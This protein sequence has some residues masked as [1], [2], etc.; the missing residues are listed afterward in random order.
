MTSQCTEEPYVALRHSQMI[1][2]KS[3]EPRKTQMFKLEGKKKKKKI[4]T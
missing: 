3:N 2:A 1:I 4:N